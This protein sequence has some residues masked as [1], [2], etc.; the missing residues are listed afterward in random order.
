MV[1]THIYG[2]KCKNGDSRISGGAKQGVFVE[3]LE[4]E[5]AK[6]GSSEANLGVFGAVIDVH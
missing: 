6:E 2:G 1:E 5:A 4:G 3:V